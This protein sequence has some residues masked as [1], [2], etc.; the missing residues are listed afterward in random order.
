LP[1]SDLLMMASFE[2]SI[3]EASRLLGSTLRPLGQLA[4]RDVIK[5]IDRADGFSAFV[6]ERPDVHDDGN[7]RAVGRFE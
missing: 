2:D 6:G 4:F 7:P 5:A 3:R 1:S